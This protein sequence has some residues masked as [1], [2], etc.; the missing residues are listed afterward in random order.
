MNTVSVTSIHDRPRPLASLVASARRIRETDRRTGQ[1]R[2]QTKQADWQDEAWDMYDL[3][4]ELRFLV[5]TLAGRIGQAKLFVGKQS[6]G[7][8]DAP[9]PIEDA[10]ISSLITAFGGTRAGQSQLLAR[11]AINL[12]IPGEGWLVGL[13]PLDDEEEERL[14]LEDSLADDLEWHMLSVSEVSAG[15]GQDTIKVTI[16]GDPYEFDPEEIYLIR[17]WNPHPRRMV[18]ADSATRAALPILKELVGLTMHISAQVDSRLA[19]AGILVVPQSAQR[20]LAVA[21]G[22]PDDDDSDVFTEALLEAMMEPINDRASASAVVPLV[23]TVPDEAADKFHHISF[24]TELDAEARNLRDEAIRRLAMSLDAPPEVMLGTADVNHWNGWLIQK[25][26]VSSHIEPPLALICDALTTQY[27]WPVLEERGYDN[28]HDYV[29]W[30]EVDHLIINPSVGSDA[31]Q[32][33]ERNALSDEALRRSM[34]FDDT[35]APRSMS[36]DPAV[37]MVL[38][39][40]QE[41]PGLLARPGTTALLQNIRALLTGQGSAP[42]E[43]VDVGPP[44]GEVIEPGGGEEPSPADGAPPEIGE[45]RGGPLG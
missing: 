31:L 36:D 21:S 12:A 27:L 41:N 1:N 40:V 34:G 28:P 20:A 45:P 14:S 3:V 25:D 42:I 33:H 9:D 22:E 39:M 23:V 29:V 37:A 10:E 35:D 4:G 2:D 18:E 43:G 38:D 8:E 32:L 19:G 5:N 11:L 30:Y 26:T 15:P 44:G 17:V 7:G 16:E 6:E 24:S 13:P